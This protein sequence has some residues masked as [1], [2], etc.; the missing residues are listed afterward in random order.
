MTIFAEYTPKLQRAVDMVISPLGYKETNRVHKPGRSTFTDRRGGYVSS[1]NDT[2]YNQ[3]FKL[4]LIQ[5]AGGWQVRIVDGATYNP[6]SGSS[7]SSLVYVNGDPYTVSLWTSPVLSSNNGFW[8]RFNTPA[9][10]QGNI[11][12]EPSVEIVYSNTAPKNDIQSAY[13]RLGR[14]QIQNGSAVVYQ[15]HTSGAVDMKWYYRFEK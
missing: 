15:D 9:D 10:E 1:A 13:Y 4:V 2:G 6:S 12:R 7:D 11:V 8:L 3:D 5:V 14:L